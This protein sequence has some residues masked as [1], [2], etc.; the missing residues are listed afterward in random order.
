MPTIIDNLI[1]SLSLDPSRFTSGQKE[2]ADALRKLEDSSER[3]ATNV[4]RQTQSV[5]TNF[6][7]ALDQP[8]QTLKK[9]FEELAGI[10][11]PGSALRRSMG[12]TATAGRSI[13][14]EVA[15]GAAAGTIA[16]RAM[17]IAGLA[18]MAGVTALFGAVKA[19]TDINKGIFSAGVGAGVAGMPIRE[20]TAVSQALFKGQNVPEADTQGW[21][22]SMRQFQENARVG[23]LDPARV[24][25]LGRAGYRGSL[26]A[27]PEEM[28]RQMAMIFAGMP[29]E[30]AE[31]RGMALGMTPTMV[32]G[33]R[34]AGLKGP[35]ALDREIAEARRTTAMTPQQQTAAEKELAAMNRLT[36][37][38]ENLER[39]FIM[40]FEQPIEKLL[41]W[42]ASWF[43]DQT[44][45]AGGAAPT[46]PI[47]PLPWEDQAPL[48]G[49]T[50]EDWQRRLRS[51]RGTGGVAGAAPSGANGTAPGGAGGGASYNAPPG[52][53]SP[54]G[55]NWEVRHNN[56]AGMRIPGVNRGPNAG[57][58]QSFATPEAGVQAIGRLLQSY[59][60]RHGL[61]TLS[62]IISRWAPPSENNTAALIARAVR[63]TGYGANQPLNLHDPE[64]LS[65]VTAAMIRGEQGGALPV[66]GGMAA[67]RHALGVGAAAHAAARQHTSMLNTIRHGARSST[68]STTNHN[69]TVNVGD[70]NVHVPP[71]TDAATTGA[72]ISDEIKR[73]MLVNQINTALV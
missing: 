11:A 51:W 49:E 62:G 4:G 44:D 8:F 40:N 67:I 20:F 65:R 9:H 33:L 42:I 73:R 68:T 38:W 52:P 34:E 5:A 60:D 7:R 18:A 53:G 56:Y 72:I 46:N 64:V 70:V 10:S 29:E 22:A 61:N 35:E 23:D 59:Q 66:P 63:D 55:G 43:P 17:G 36:A 24:L 50:Y 13:G 3:A 41:N 54:T 16:L 6:F 26:L 48:P 25:A 28:L 39:H 31:Q 30:T 14:V 21:L 32:H 57:G 12:A 69:S 37:A 2:A 58:F 71:G 45:V 47:V 19:V 15:E 1:V 27:S